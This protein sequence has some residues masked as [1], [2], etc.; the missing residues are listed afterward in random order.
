MKA[1]DYVNEGMSSAHCAMSSLQN[2]IQH[3]EKQANK[4]VIQKAMDEMQHACECL[5]Q[6]QD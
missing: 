3:A 1:Q 4:Q 6:F 2:A 5:Q